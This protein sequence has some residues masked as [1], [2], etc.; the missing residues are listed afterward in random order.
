MTL[1]PVVKIVNVV[2]VIVEIVSETVLHSSATISSSG[3]NKFHITY[4]VGETVTT[5]V[6]VMKTEQSDLA[7]TGR[8][9]FRLESVTVRARKQLS[10]MQPGG[11]RL[12]R[13]TFADARNENPV[14]RSRESFIV[15]EEWGLG[16]DG[17]YWCRDSGEEGI[18]FIPANMILYPGGEP[19]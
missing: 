14:R 17:E 16:K 7:M 15:T 13:N 19:L 6:A 2:E 11:A 5:E 18:V 4:A 8:E 3:W 9:V 10:A 1:V 12:S